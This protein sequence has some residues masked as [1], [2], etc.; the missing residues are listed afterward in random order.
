MDEPA[1]YILEEMSEPTTIE[2]N[3][4]HE[5]FYAGDFAE[6]ESRAQ[7]LLSQH[8]ES[9]FV[10]NALG[11]ALQ[12]QGKDG[13]AALRRATGLLPNDADMHCKLGNALSDLGRLNE[14]EA[15]FRRALEIKPDYAEVHSN[16]GLTLKELGR[17]NEAEACY[18]QA[19]EIKPDYAEAHSN[20][21]LTLRELGRL[22]EAEASYRQALEIRPDFAEAYGNL[23]G[24]LK[25]QG[26]FDEALAYYRQSGRLMPENDDIQHQIASLSG[27]TTERAP[28]K[29][30]EK[31]FDGYAHKFDRHLQQ[32]LKYEV[33]EKIVALITKHVSPPV[34]KWNVLDLGCGTGLA[35]LAI[36]P[37][38]RRLVG[39]DLSSKMLEKASA[40]NLY[41]RLEHLDLMVMMRREAASSFDVIV[42]T[43]VFIYVGRLDDVFGETKRLLRPDG[44]V[45]F[46]IE[47]LEASAQGEASQGVQPEYQLQYTGRYS[48]SQSYIT[49][50]A[51][52][53]GFKIQGIEATLIRTEKGKPINGHLV[54]LRKTS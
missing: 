1:T 41:Q 44:I 22:A 14:A 49:S 17:L 40:R 54:L 23:G 37:F 15:S 19:L 9:G 52:A 11:L 2:R 36:A 48:H 13:S 24:L 43:D 16:L 42:A 50:L 7:A 20:L 53:S 32:D 29:Y 45:A 34:E 10:W 25:E 46:S 51:S 4:L 33:P 47:T 38:A 8:P 6:V 21:G 39:V 12:M 3:Q 5:L 26:K 35:G 31:L 27:R 30:V 28:V 18:R